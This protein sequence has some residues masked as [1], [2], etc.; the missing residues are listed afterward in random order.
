MYT[1]NDLQSMA[2]LRRAIQLYAATLPEEL[3]REVAMIYPAYA[4]GQAYKAGD[5][6]TDGT[7]ANGDPLLY[8]VAQ[9][10]TSQEDW[11]PAGTPALYIC[12]SLTSGGYPIWSPPSGAHDAYNSGDIVSHTGRLWRSEIDGNTTE[13]GTDGR[14]WSVYEEV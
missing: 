5:Y 2:Q 3:S 9:D 10:H 6:I 4:V 11:P 7:D 8:K 12:V 1:K 14:W 13:P